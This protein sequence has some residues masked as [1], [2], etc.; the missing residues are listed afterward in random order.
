[1]QLLIK[2]WWGGQRPVFR[3]AVRQSRFPGD[4]AARFS[5]EVPAQVFTL[6]KAFSPAVA[7]FRADDSGPLANSIQSR[8]G[9]NAANMTHVRARDKRNFR[10]SAGNT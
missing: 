2:R 3:P 7:G 10:D 6:G 8:D 5:E 4:Y 9:S 1:M